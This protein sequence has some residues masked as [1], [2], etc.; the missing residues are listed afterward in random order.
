MMKE[1]KD[2]KAKK[3]S[4][5]KK[6]SILTAVFAILT[7][8]SIVGTN[9][10][11]SAGQAINIFLKTDTYKVVDK[12][13]GKE[14]TTYFESDFDSVEALEENG[15][16]VAEQLHAEGSVLLKNNGVLPLKEGSKVSTLSHSSVDMVT[17][18]TGAADIDT[19]NAPTLKEALESR[20]FSVNA[21]LWD[22]YTKGAGKEYVR[23]PGK[24]AN[25]ENQAGRA[26]WNIN[27][28][29]ASAYTE[30]VKSSFA[31]YKDAAIVTISRISGEGAD[32]AV[33]KF[34]DGENVLSLTKEEQEMLKMAKSNFEDVIVLINSTNALECDFIDNEEYGIDAVLWI[35]YT[36]GWGLN[37]VADILAGNA[38]PSG[39]LVDTY[40]YDNTTAPSMV[41][42]YGDDFTNYDPKDEKHWYSVANGQLDG[43][44]H[45]IT[46]QEGI[47]VGYRYYETRYEDVVM[48]TANA[49]DYD[50][51]KTVAYP[52]G[53]GL[54]YTEFE[55]S[56]FKTEYNKDTD[57]FEVSVKVTNTG[58]ME[59][60]EVVQIYFQSPYTEYD[61]ENG[62]EKASVEL[63]GFDKTE[64][65][66]PGASE[67]VTVNVPREELACYDENGAK[68]Y[69]LDAGDYYLIAAKNAHDA[70]NNVLAAKGYT[71]ADGMTADGNADFAYKYNNKELDT[72]TYSVS[73]ATGEKITNQF[74]SADLSQYGYEMKYLSRSDWEGTWPKEMEIEATEEMFADGLY[75]YQT[76]KGI[77][78]SKTEMPTMGADN[79]LTLAMMIGKDFDDPAWEDLLD[80]VTFEEMATLIGQGYHNTAV[81]PSVSKPAT[82]DDNGPQG[83]T[84][85][86]TGVSECHTAYADE[87]IMAA[88][89]NVDLME[90]LGKAL[91]NDVLDLGASGLYGPAMN[92]HRNAYAGRN[93]EY[94]SEDG[95]LSGAIAAAE[96]KGIQ[97]KG[98]YVYIKHFA[99]NDSETACR[100]I[101][102]WA[103]EQSIRE[104]YL[105]PFEMAIVDG[106]AM[107]VMNSFARFGVVWSG[108]HEGLMTNVLRGEWGMKGFGLTDFSGNAQFETYGLY[109]K[110]FDVANGLLAGT[111]CWDSSSMSWTNDLN[112]LYKDDPDIVQAMRQATHRI[113]YTVANSN[114]MNGLSATQQVVAVTPWWQ[115]ALYAVCTVM[116]AMTVLS[117]VMIFRCKKKQKG[118]KE[119]AQQ[120]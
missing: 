30:D 92:I 102:T 25:Q 65:L 53:Y 7:A 33:D 106:G 47:Y 52:F 76:Y 19:S 18:G 4:G 5:V 55:Y 101:S 15:R 32:L 35:G 27:E 117:I 26:G 86:L 3:R 67:V 24:E 95:F 31:Q 42:I 99:L 113:L 38:N 12:G 120:A 57:S 114:A 28:V 6:W 111:D 105:K 63:C 9:I 51:S 104:V 64:V 85:N 34:K 81:V 49:G 71:K 23:T 70:V 100:C 118:E 62:I 87:N 98:V 112:K 66:K 61:K 41:G 107:N 96:V 88:T 59:G 40:C 58:D 13:N 109:M 115:T 91:G 84:Q 83:F 8:V 116:G 10:A 54:S 44:H 97:S 103:N 46:Y 1:K 79:G 22:F 119:A 56:D 29:P 90:E 14:D 2:A 75:G 21:T 73:R 77:E 17:C 93:F 82:V 72:E 36:G 94:Y 50:Y 45:Y 68:T 37:G 60:K 16:K 11:L 110:T 48:G 74:E 89:Y 69:I 108:A 20:G 78:D 39:R 80:Q 43:N